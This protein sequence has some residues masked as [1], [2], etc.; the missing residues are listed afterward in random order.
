MQPA[1]DVSRGFGPRPCDPLSLSLSAVLRVP[2]LSRGT[3]PSENFVSRNLE[4]R[5]QANFP[6]TLSASYTGAPHRGEV[7]SRSDWLRVDLEALGPDSV[8]VSG[9]PLRGTSLAFAL[10][11][12]SSV[13]AAQLSCHS[14]VAVTGHL[15]T[16][17]H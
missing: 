2:I 16:W 1:F 17:V 10:S 8:L 11:R 14:R 7:F 4:I 9:R 13:C 12:L 3:D 6:L 5:Y 15:G